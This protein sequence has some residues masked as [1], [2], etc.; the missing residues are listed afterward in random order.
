MRN[1]LSRFGS[2]LRR[3]SVVLEMIGKMAM[4]TAQ[5]V[6]AQVVSSTQMMISGAMAADATAKAR[7]ERLLGE[8]DK[9]AET[10]AGEDVDGGDYPISEYSSM[11]D[12]TE[13]D[14]DEGR[15]AKRAAAQPGGAHAG[16]LEQ[17]VQARTSK[18]EER[19]AQLVEEN[20]RKDASH[21]EALAAK[22]REFGVE[23]AKMLEAVSLLK[24][25]QNEL[26]RLAPPLR[27]AV[28]NAKE[29]LRAVVCS[30]EKLAELQAK[31][32]AALSLQEFTIL[33]VH[34][35]TANLRAELDVCRV[36]RDS[37]SET[38]R[39]FEMD[40]ARLS[41][42]LKQ[43]REH[44]ARSDADAD[45]ERAALDSRC[46]R[47]ARELEDAMVKVE[48]LS[49]KGAMYDEV[50]S[51][52]DRLGKRCAEAEKDLAVAKGQEQLLREERDGLASKL[53]SRQHQ[54][55]LLSQDKA[56]LTREVDALADR[57]RKREEEEDRLRE[58]ARALRVSRDALQEKVLSGNAEF[59][60]QHEERLNAEVARL[61]QKA[62]E[63]LERLREEHASARDREIRALRDLRDAAVADSV[64]ARAELNDLRGAYD[65][66]LAQHRASQTRADV[67][68]AEITGQLRMKAMELE[69]VSMLHGESQSV[70][71]VLRLECETL[72]KK[73]RLLESQYLGLEASAARRRA[74]A[75]ARSAE[76]AARLEH[77]ESLERELDD[78]VMLAAGAI[79]DAGAA[80]GED[81]PNPATG[82]PSKNNNPLLR[83]ADSVASALGALGASV[84]ASLRRRLAQNVALGR[85][86]HELERLLRAANAERDQATQRAETLEGSLRRANSKAHDATQLARHRTGFGEVHPRNAAAIRGRVVGCA[87]ARPAAA[88]RRDAEMMGRRARAR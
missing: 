56:Y 63:D 4:I 44:V 19:I 6:S 54:V 66:L 15:R 59:R 62:A 77:Y 26:E 87:E 28:Q 69:R 43:A 48:V 88:L 86:C 41:R 47:L 25:K 53:A 85:R 83:S 60:S 24:N 13:S 52:V 55:D 58:K 45:A 61:Q 36:E 73:V 80:A 12:V 42:E 46:S 27:E 5:T 33:R 35:E 78:A 65:D 84:P 8:L 37:K 79:D 23:R 64:A 11:S 81:H 34:Q 49:A 32:P 20:A 51:T 9:S 14:A 39:R 68:R 31:D 74:E 71:K 75:D 67:A 50:A 18:L 70:A 38:S 76:Q 1:M 10:P 16:R 17:K 2:T 30:Q 29:Q 7:L 21:K 82:S 57:E 22:D 40:A 3:P 72:T